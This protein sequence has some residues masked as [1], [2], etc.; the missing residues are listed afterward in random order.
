MQ[1]IVNAYRHFPQVKETPLGSVGF[2]I[3]NVCVLFRVFRSLCS[4]F[5]FSLKN[6]KIPVHI[7]SFRLLVSVRERST[8]EVNLKDL[9]LQRKKLLLLRIQKDLQA[10]IFLNKW[11]SHLFILIYCNTETL[12]WSVNNNIYRPITILNTCLS[13]PWSDRAKILFLQNDILTTHK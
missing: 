7:Y 9:L 11:R 2:F 6:V 10:K 13:T 1:L 8:A 12:F 3:E 4:K 5:E